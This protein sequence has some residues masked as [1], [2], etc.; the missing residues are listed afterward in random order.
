V[1]TSATPRIT[2]RP[3]WF[4]H[5]QSSSTCFVRSNFSL[6]F[7]LTVMVSPS[8]TGREKCSVWSM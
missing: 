4:T 5:A 3:S 8:V 2:A 1:S 7:T 6:T